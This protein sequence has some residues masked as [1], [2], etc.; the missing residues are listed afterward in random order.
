MQGASEEAVAARE[1]YYTQ[2]HLRAVRRGLEA[3]ARALAVVARSAEGEQRVVALDV[4]DQLLS[5]ADGIRVALEQLR[6]PDGCYT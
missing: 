6:E 4:V 1:A 2:A 5:L 3:D